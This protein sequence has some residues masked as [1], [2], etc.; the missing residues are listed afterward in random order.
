MSPFA[1]GVFH[2]AAAAGV[3][4][5]AIVYGA[6]DCDYDQAGYGDDCYNC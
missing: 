3:S 6:D 4:F 2:R 5:F 1:A